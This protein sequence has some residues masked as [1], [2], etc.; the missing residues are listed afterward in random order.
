MVMIGLWRGWFVVVAAVGLVASQT[1]HAAGND[2]AHMDA[3]E[4]KALERRLTDAGCYKGLMT[5]K[6]NSPALNNAIEACP[7]QQ[8]K[9]C[10]S[11]LSCPPR[12]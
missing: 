11:R 4:I 12:L 9:T 3:D 8:P 6:K 2:P 5:A 7:D 10:V 1:A